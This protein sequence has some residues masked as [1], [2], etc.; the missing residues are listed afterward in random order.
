VE[1][2]VEM[3]VERPTKKRSRS[4]SRRRTPSVEEGVEVEVN[5]PRKS[6]TYAPKIMSDDNKRYDFEDAIEHRK[7]ENDNKT[8]K[9]QFGETIFGTNTSI[10]RPENS[11]W[12]TPEEYENAKK[13]K[14]DETD[15]FGKWNVEYVDK[16]KIKLCDPETGRCLVFA[17]A[18][19]AVLGRMAGF[20]GGTRRK[21]KG[22]SKTRKFR[23][24]MR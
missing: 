24:S 16:K 20:F 18:A 6:V 11:F 22:N 14:I 2:G 3:E 19:G 23:R 12:Q 5:R 9:N 7:R 21:K 10:E 15:I 13:A 4:A 8:I 1:E 17:L